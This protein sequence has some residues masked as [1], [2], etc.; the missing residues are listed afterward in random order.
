MKRVRL[1]MPFASAEP[2]REV[3]AQ[4]FD[5]NGRELQAT[6]ETFGQEYNNYRPHSSLGYLTPAKSAGRY[7]EKNQ[8]K[9]VKQPSEKAGSLSF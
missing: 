9:G 1:R 2:T 6:V 8:V 4:T 7:Y 5:P 3:I